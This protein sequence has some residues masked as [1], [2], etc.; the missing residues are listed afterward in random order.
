[1]SRQEVPQAG[2]LKAAL[3]EKITNEHGAGRK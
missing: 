1:M 3:A 2:L